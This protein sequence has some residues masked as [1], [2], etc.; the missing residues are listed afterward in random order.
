M[1]SSAS[2][3]AGVRRSGVKPG[4]SPPARD[5][6]VEQS[7]RGWPEDQAAAELGA[8]FAEALGLDQQ[9]TAP[10]SLALGWTP[11]G[12]TAADDL[13]TGSYATVTNRT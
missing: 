8:P 6:G 3:N 11:T 10:R 4:S 5:A 7:A 12:R 2:A 9:V 1:A 13:A